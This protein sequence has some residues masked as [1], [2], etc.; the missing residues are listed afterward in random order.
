M[1][2]VELLAVHGAVVMALKHPLN[3]GLSSILQRHFL[4]TAEMLLEEHGIEEP[5]EGWRGVI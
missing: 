2:L 1:T 3:C 5:P 4:D